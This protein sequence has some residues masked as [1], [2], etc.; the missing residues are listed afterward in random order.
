M[1][2]AVIIQ[3]TVRKRFTITIPE[4]TIVRAVFRRFGGILME[5]TTLQMVILR[6]A[7]TKLQI[8]IRLT[9]IKHSCLTTWAAIIADWDIR[10]MYITVTPI[11]L[12]IQQ[13]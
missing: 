4:V 8:I 11:Q 13:R 12:I 9:D 7:I 6:L 3:P 1:Q 5:V 2:P 10:P